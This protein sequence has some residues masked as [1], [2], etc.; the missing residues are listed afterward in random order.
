MP[1][2]ARTGRIVLDFAARKRI[3]MALGGIAM[4]ALIVAIACGIVLALVVVGG[5]RLI[6][7]RQLVLLALF[8]FFIAA[9]TGNLGH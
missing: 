4:I 9:V 6:F 5:F 2:F 3:G 8:A 1:I 7:T